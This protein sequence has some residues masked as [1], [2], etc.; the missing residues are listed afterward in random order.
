MSD[1]P[2]A[3]YEAIVPIAREDAERAFGSDDAL[4]VVHALLGAALHD[5]DPSWVQDACIR[6]MTHD[7]VWV[8]RACLTSLSHLSRLHETVDMKRARIVF[9]HL[10]HDPEV[11]GDVEVMESDVKHWRRLWRRE[12]GQ[13]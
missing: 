13:R 10:R 11:A 6:L 8:R 3:R 12:R 5:D 9:D 2:A 4:E 1:P 7:D